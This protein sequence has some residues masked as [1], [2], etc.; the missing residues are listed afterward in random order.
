[1]CGIAGIVSPF[2]LGPGQVAA[3]HR[4]QGNMM[5]RGP[6]GEGEHLATNAHIAIRRLSIID[7]SGGW[8]PL[9]NEDRSLAVVANG[10]IYNF[11]ELRADLESRGHVF[12]TGSDC[13]TIL[14]LYEELGADCVRKLRGMFAFALWDEKQGRLLLA[15]DR[16]GEKPLYLAEQGGDLIFASE[17]KALLSSGML[18]LDLDPV[19]LNLFFHY[20]FVPEPGVPLKGIRKLPAAHTLLWERTKSA[21]RLSRYWRVDEAPEVDTAKALD[22]AAVVLD[23]LR[24]TMRLVVRSDVPVGVA[25]SGGIDSSAVA[26]LASKV[27]SSLQAVA[28]GYR[29]CPDCDERAA[30]RAFARSLG[31]P[32]HE[33]EIDL[34]EL[35]EFFPEMV[36]WTDDLIADV[37]G[38]GYYAVMRKAREMGIPVMLQGHGGDEIFWGY[39]WVKDSVERAQAAQA[40][41]AGRLAAPVPSFDV[42]PNYLAAVQEMPKLWSRRFRKELRQILANAPFTVELPWERP[43]LLLTRLIIE[44]YLLG[45]GIN[46]GDRLG[47]ASAVELRLPLVDYRLVE[48]VVGLRKVRPDH[49]LPPKARLK[50]ALSNIL[51]KELLV[52][53]K[54][55]FAPP[56]DKWIRA[57]RKSYGEELRN[58]LL[59]DWEIFDPERGGDLLDD[60]YVVWRGSPIFYKALVLEYWLRAMSEAQRKAAAEAR[61]FAAGERGAEIR[62]G[63][64]N[65]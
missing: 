22:P 57:L 28:V 55:G 14:H 50:D 4:M 32:L 35:I 8:Q 40:L 15:R 52:R 10:E 11:V 42:T 12:R 38:Y 49:A 24:E 45:N 18:P 29:D 13:E 44:I 61:A 48:T 23:M 41:V 39:G 54:R 31:I 19:G 17:L 9:Y 1:M 34:H 36:W 65:G 33:A 51:P 20:N 6:D 30:A 37:A 43:D 64:A 3:V 58:G 26:A 16:M 60:R 62:W 5:H 21:Y 47:M 2:P 46:Q 63:A 7:L 53:P 56:V 25:L 27:Y 59:V